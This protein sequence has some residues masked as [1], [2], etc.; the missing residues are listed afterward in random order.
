MKLKLDDKGNV[1]VQ[2]G[3]PVYTD[4][5]GKDIAFDAPATIATITRLNGEAKNHREGKEAAE[6]K[7]AKFAG[8]DDPAA[9]IAALATVKNLKDKQLV[10]A[11]EVEKVKAEA[12]KAVE[13]KYAP[14]VKENGELK[15][16]LHQEK[17]GGSFSRSK[18]I[19]DKLA[20]PADLV[21][22]RFGKHF[23]IKDGK[24]VA[25]DAAGNPIYSKARPGEVADFDEAMEFLVDAY[26]QKDSILK[27]TSGAGGGAP[28]KGNPPGA[29]QIKRVDFDK[30]DPA[31]Q[32][33]KVV[34][35]GFT[36]I[37]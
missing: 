15:T 1:I 13:D 23:E 5:A 18:F 33:T 27:G 12:I 30:L 22:A 17:I 31:T 25:K 9:A 7:L 21:E 2:D 34:K 36:V 11:G 28:N 4:D 32:H 10:D 6:A 26:P 24:V 8:I 20:I 19:A 37:D 14:V 16:A 29:K 3:K 35:D